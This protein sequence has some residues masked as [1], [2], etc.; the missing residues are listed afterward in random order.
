[1]AT[2]TLT[3]TED[4]YRALYSEKGPDESFSDVVIK[5]TT[6]RG[7]ISSFSGKW[8]DMDESELRKAQKTF[9]KSWKDMEDDMLRL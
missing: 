7:R 6:G 9:D 5:L 4:A 3:I 8:K 2:K 1:M